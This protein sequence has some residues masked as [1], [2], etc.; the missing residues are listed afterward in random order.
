MY[1][2]VEVQKGKSEYFGKRNP[3]TLIGWLVYAHLLQYVKLMFCPIGWDFSY[4]SLTCGLAGDLASLSVGWASNNNWDFFFFT[5]KRSYT[6]YDIYLIKVK[7]L[8]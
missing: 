3:W 4:G 6:G 7:P 2:S 1:K 5:F 8:K